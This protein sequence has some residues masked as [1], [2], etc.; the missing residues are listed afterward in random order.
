MKI[1]KSDR[2]KI[3]ILK[4]LAKA[5][6]DLSYYAA[7]KQLKMNDSVF[8]PNCRFLE[9]LELVTVRVIQ[10]PNGRTYHYVAITRQGRDF[11]ERIASAG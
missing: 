11:L 5:K 8:F 9:W 2:L 7:M 10:I 4:E 6:D 3:R 1:V